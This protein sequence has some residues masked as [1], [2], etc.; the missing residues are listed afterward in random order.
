[1]GRIDLTKVYTAKEMSEKIGKNRNYLSQAFRNNKTAI[2]KDFTYRKIGSTLL[3]SDD[4]T[5]DL[6]QL[7]PAKEASRLIGKN[8][9]YFAHV[10]RRTPHRFEGISHIYKG[11]TLFLT[12]EAIQRFCQRN[13]TKNVR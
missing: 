6:S 1:M 12:K 8:D 13:T 4:P 7:V 9:E 5:N 3:F 10:Y 11:K 2:L